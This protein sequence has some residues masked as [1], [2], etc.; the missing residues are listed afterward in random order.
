MAEQQYAMAHFRKLS[1]REIVH[2]FKVSV[3]ISYRELERIERGA[4]INM[5]EDCF[6]DTSEVLTAEP[7]A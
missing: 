3:P 6:L 1:N 4:L 7:A 5:R 2:S